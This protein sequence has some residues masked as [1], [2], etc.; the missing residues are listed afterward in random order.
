MAARSAVSR[1]R[2]SGEVTSMEKT[3]FLRYLAGR[4]MLPTWGVV[5]HEGV[6]S[7]KYSSCLDGC[8]WRMAVGTK[9]R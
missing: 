6:K 8:Y 7:C 9:V 1:R 2:W 5:R 3:G 4:L